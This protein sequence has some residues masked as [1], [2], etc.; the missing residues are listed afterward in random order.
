[1]LELSSH[2]QIYLGPDDAWNISP[3]IVYLDFVYTVDLL[4]I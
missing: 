3:H 4:D 2:H 1:M